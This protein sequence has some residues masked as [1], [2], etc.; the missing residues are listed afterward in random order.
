MT[1]KRP[2]L[3]VEN[4]FLNL[5]VPR[6]LRHA[7]ALLDTRYAKTRTGHRTIERSKSRVDAFP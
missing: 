7:R 1:Q 2:P 3:T 4:A 5:D 6:A